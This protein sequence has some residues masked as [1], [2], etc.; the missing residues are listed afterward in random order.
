MYNSGGNNY[1]KVWLRARNKQNKL[2]YLKALLNKKLY[3][4]ILTQIMFERVKQYWAIALS[5]VTTAL[6]T[7]TS[8]GVSVET[9]DVTNVQTANGYFLSSSFEIL[10]FIPTIAVLAAWMWVLNKVFSFVPKAG[11]GQ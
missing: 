4:I 11:W 3:L 9:A 1:K 2:N 8:T 5:A 7:V 10:K 6:L